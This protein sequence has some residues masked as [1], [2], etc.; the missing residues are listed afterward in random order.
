MPGFQL[1][2]EIEGE[3]QFSR[4]LL[5]AAEGLENFTRPLSSIGSELLQSFQVNF[6][7]RGALFGGWDPPARDYGH[8]LLED[9]GT[10]RDSF[11]SIVEAERVFL[12]N[13]TPYF[14]YHQSK[15]ARSKIPRRV[16]MMINDDNRKMIVREF[17]EYVREVIG[18]S[19]V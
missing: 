4:R 17:Q 6:D 14:P 10:M 5:V 18:L 16:M 8:P 2:I 9:S 13:L 15:Q 1:N 7:Q 11:D 3:R 12:F 19:R